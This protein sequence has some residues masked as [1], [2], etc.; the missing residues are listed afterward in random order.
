[1]K[2]GFIGAGKVG[3]AFGA[4]LQRKGFALQGYFSRSTDSAL[5]AAASTNSFV[6]ETAKAL[7]KDVDFLWITTTDDHIKEVCD[8][9]AEENAFRKGQI[10]A[11]MSGASSSRILYRAKE[12][13][14]FIY[15][16]HPLQSFAD[17]GKAIEDLEHTYFSIEG[18]GEKMDVIEGLFQKMGNRT[19]RIA[20]EHKGLYHAAACIFSNYL[21]T[22]MH[23]GLA[24]F[25]KIGIPKKEGFQAVLPL[26]LGTIENI[27]ALGTA[28]AL[29]GPIAR[30]DGETIFHHIQS[31]E[32]KMPETL[33]FYKMMGQMTFHLASVHKLKDPEKK[34]GLKKILSEV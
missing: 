11:H 24:Y 4:Y 9:L 28:I 23:Q 2:M 34:E 27:E 1:M 10:V 6:Y 30:G 8:H 33:W 31:I 21:V 22:L 26:I 32:E 5:K 7:A 20:T 25:E 19:F 15:S 14:C 13:G 17:I 3:T 16:I 29:T 12:K 18:D